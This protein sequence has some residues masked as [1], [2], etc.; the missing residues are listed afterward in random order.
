MPAMSELLDKGVVVVA[1]IGINHQG[2]VDIAKQ[3]IAAAQIAG[4]DVVKFQKRTPE[5]CVPRDQWDIERDTLWGRMSYLDYRKKIEFSYLD[6]Q[7]IDT[8]CKKI[9]MPWTAS[10][11]D[12]A[13]CDFIL[14]FDTPFIKIPSAK[15]TDHK[16]LL[17]I[18]DTDRSIVLS[19]GMSTDEEVCEAVGII[20]YRPKKY[21]NLPFV[22]MQCT[23]TYPC[24]PSELNILYIQTMTQRPPTSY[25]IPGYS[26]HETGIPPTLAAVALGAKVIERHLTLNRA[27][28]G[29]DHAASLEP[30]AMSTLV[31][32]IRTVER[33]LGNGLKRV[34]ESEHPAM[35]KLRG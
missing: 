19:T 8:Y 35:A 1:E 18:G 27:W 33:S 30:V 12:V 34:Y 24:D 23:S 14:A 2:E 9:G 6:Y 10:V 5:Q 21:R 22:L 11:W 26:G 20:N 25:C 32:Q 15:L 16:L 7:E 31:R 29:T 13:S 3:L 4:C 17:H 28:Q